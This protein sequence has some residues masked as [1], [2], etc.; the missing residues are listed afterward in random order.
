[1]EV[2][3]I[4]SRLDYLDKPKVK[5]FIDEE[6]AFWLY[7]KEIIQYHIKEGEEIT[8]QI[9]EVILRDIILHRAKNKAVA[10]LKF[11]DR[12]EYEIMKKLSDAGYPEGI[13]C[14]VLAYLN[15]YRYIDDDKYA[16]TYVRIKKNTKSKRV[17]K[18]EMKQKGIKKDI[19]DRVLSLEYENEE[20]EDPE[21]LAIKKAIEK[22]HIDP[23]N[24]SKEEKQ[25]VLA[26]LYRKGFEIDKIIRI[27]M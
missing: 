16:A 20:L 17:I 12:T 27:L 7:E 23:S 13:V 11:M 10:I 15:E 9:H 5:V 14:Q 19:I 3:L 22:K 4:I 8:S 18:M 2:K 24:L 1:M 25:K 6:Y 21:L 26:S